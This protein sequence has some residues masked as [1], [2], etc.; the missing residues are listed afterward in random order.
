[1][2]V[3]PTHVGVNRYTTP[4]YSTAARIPHARGGEPMTV[5]GPVEFSHVFPTHVGVNRGWCCCLILSLS[6]PH[7]RGGEPKYGAEVWA[8]EPYSPRTWG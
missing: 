5:L 1:M 2:D 4:L 6:I 3:F 7:A 8:Y